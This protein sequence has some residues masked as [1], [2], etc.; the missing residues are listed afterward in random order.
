M[1][2]VY[3]KWHVSIDHKDGTNLN[4]LYL[5]VIKSIYKIYIIHIGNKRGLSEWLL[6][7]ISKTFN[8]ILAIT[9]PSI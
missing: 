6:I 1:R 7:I 8:S 5:Y 3:A 4:N 2:V 9:S